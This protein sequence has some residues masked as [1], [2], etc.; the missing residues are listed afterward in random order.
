FLATS[1]AVIAMPY[2]RGAHAAGKLSVGFWDHWVPGANKASQALCEEWAAKEKVEL[3]IDYIPSQ[4]FKLLLT[5]AAEAQAQSGHDIIGFRSWHPADPA[6]RLDPVDDIRAELIKQNG[7]VTPTVESLARSTG[8]WVA[9]PA[10]VGS[11]IKGPCSRI[12]LM[13]SLAGIDVQALY[14]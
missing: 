1:T 14:P 13:K 7:A 5:I 2:V 11:Q 9:V 6:N 12:D 8:R 4:G 3:S 10:C